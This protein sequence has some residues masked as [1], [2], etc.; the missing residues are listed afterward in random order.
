[1]QLLQYTPLCQTNSGYTMFAVMVD[2]LTDQQNKHPH[3]NDEKKKYVK[4]RSRLAQ[5]RVLKL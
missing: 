5:K 4:A 1:M 2:T 3:K